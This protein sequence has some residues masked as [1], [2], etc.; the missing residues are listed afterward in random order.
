M[1]GGRMSNLALNIIKLSVAVFI[2]SVS[3]L[4]LCLA[5]RAYYKPYEINGYVIKV[6]NG[7]SFSWE[8][9]HR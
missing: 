9:K 6:Y 7:K 5:H 2:L 4:I 1:E 3:V 8:E